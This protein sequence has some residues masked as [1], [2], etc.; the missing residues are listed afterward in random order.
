MQIDIDKSSG[1]CFGVKR[2]IEKAEELLKQGEELYCLGEIVHNHGEVKRLNQSGMTTISLNDAKHFEGKTILLRSHGEPPSTYSKLTSQ[3]NKL[4]DAT[5]P[6]V[7]K[8]QRRIKESYLSNTKEDGQLVIFGKEGH[9]EVIGLLGQAENKAIVVSQLA[10]LNR[11][12]FD[13]PIE[14]YCQTTMSLGA[15]YEIAEFL[16]KKARNKLIIHD[17][18]CRQVANRVPHLRV[19]A[20]NYDLILFISGKKSS[21]G[22]FLFEVCQSENSNSH[23]ISSP[24]EIELNWLEGIESIG[25]CGGTSTPQWQM[26]Q[27]KLRIE[28]ISEERL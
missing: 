4:I 20:T 28:H 21:N 2:A 23:F 27:V 19:F 16:K 14:L 5:C 18:I 9:P 11:L 25:I 26:E 3:Q 15:F 6:V 17:T 12:D 24:D 1:F 22:K 13:Q 7:L 10:E 8:L